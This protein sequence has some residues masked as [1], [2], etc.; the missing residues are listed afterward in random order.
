MQVQE[1]EKEKNGEEMGFQ[2]INCAVGLP[3][4]FTI[5]LR[6]SATASRCKSITTSMDG[7]SANTCS[8]A[9]VL[10]KVLYGETGAQAREAAGVEIEQ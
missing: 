8:I 7:F 5:S 4:R 2:N 6:P 3:C 10:A 9:H 1:D